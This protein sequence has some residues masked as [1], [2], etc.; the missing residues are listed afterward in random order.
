MLRARGSPVHAVAWAGARSGGLRA[1]MRVP[2]SKE[3][4][5]YQ[6]NRNRRHSPGNES[7]ANFFRLPPWRPAAGVDHLAVSGHCRRVV[8]AVEREHERPGRRALVFGR[9]EAP[10]ERA[11][12]GGLP[13]AAL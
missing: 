10:V 3:G 7:P 6:S 2:E 9:R 1:L 13:L 8:V 4:L 12:G 11:A 5:A